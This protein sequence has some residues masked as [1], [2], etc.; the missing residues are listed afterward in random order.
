M[1]VRGFENEDPT[2][3][4]ACRAPGALDIRDEKG[5][6]LLRELGVK[7][8]AERRGIGARIAEVAGAL[9]L[10]GVRG[11]SSAV[12]VTVHENDTY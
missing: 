3:A 10:S 7:L 1:T 2:I 9:V 4:T 5:K 6:I 12:Q 11:H 8:A